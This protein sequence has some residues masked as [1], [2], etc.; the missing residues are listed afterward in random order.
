MGQYQNIVG[1][2][3]GSTNATASYT[4]LYT[5][6]LLTRT[7][8]KDINI[9][10]VTANKHQAYVHLVPSGGTPDI[11]NA[12]VYNFGI[13]GGTI[14]NWRGL[15]IMNEGDTIQV[16]SDTADR[17]CIYISGADAT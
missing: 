4:T 9:C 1:K 13:D 2:K 8:V 15:A 17:L 11:T 5:V 7:Y 14:Y 6:P 16:K 3:L 10:N 12:I